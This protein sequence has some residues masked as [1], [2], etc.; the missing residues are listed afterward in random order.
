MTSRKGKLIVGLLV[1]A[2]A[3]GSLEVT[4]A[5]AG[6]PSPIRLAKRALK[7]AKAADKRSKQALK[8]AQQKRGAD[9]THGLA[10]GPEGPAGAQG[11]GG[12][13]GPAGPDGAQRPVGPKGAD[14]APG[15]AG[16][17][18]AQG[19]A[20]ADGAQGAAGADGAQGAAGPQ[21]PAGADGADGAPGPQGPAGP[22]GPAG[23]VGPQGP[24]GAVGPQGPAGADGPQGPAGPEG[25]QGAPGVTIGASIPI[26]APIGFNQTWSNQP[27]GL[28]ELS[29]TTR[30][31][32]RFDLTNV[33]K[34][35]LVVNVQTA[36][37]PTAELCVEYSLDQTTWSALDGGSGSCA[38]INTTGVR[39]SP[40]PVIALAARGDVYLRVVGANGN[41]TLDP[42]FGHISI[43]VR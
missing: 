33:T 8:L 13:Q 25:P 9:G 27:A 29:G 36:G 18:G 6:A 19:P 22:P 41:G 7:L 32:T 11:A 26:V 37:A 23:A 38:P 34:A 10:T 16:K 4:A 14:G 2:L 12:A 28:T 39:V 31:R 40:F 30:H 5:T 42:A 20:G 24:A 1:G 21:G 17:D 3:V 43:E 15:Q 35:R